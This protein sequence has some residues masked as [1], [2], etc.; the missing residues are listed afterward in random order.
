MR[1]LLTGYAVT[2]NLRHRR[3]GHLFQNRYKSIVNRGL[4]DCAEKA[5]RSESRH[6]PWA[7]SWR[8]DCRCAILR[9]RFRTTTW[10]IEQ[11]P[12]R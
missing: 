11:S 7:S 6:L 5:D 10:L 9:I 3:S 4:G 1:R 2:F 12:Q 8:I